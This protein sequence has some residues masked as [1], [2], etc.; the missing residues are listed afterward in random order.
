MAGLAAG[1]AGCSAQ[2]R[3]L[4]LELELKISER[5]LDFFLNFSKFSEI[6]ENLKFFRFFCVSLRSADLH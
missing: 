6:S 4:R 5:V 1:Q 2:A 3:S